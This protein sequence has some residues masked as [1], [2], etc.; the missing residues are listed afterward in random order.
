MIEVKVWSS[1]FLIVLIANCSLIASSYAAVPPLGDANCKEGS[2][3][4][5]NCASVD[6]SFGKMMNDPSSPCGCCKLCIFYIGENE[7][8]GVNMNNR[9]CG[10]GLTCAVQNP[11]SEYI[12]VKLETDCFKAQTDYDDRKSSGSLGMYETRPRCDDNGDFIARKCQP[13][14]SCYCVDVANNR[15]FGES[16]PSYATSD[17][18]MNCEC[19]RAYQ[20]AAQQDSLRT[21]QFP[22]CLPNGNYDLLQCV[23]Q[24]CFCIDSA[25]QTLTSSIQPITAI[26]E[27]PCYKADLH[28]P[29]YYRPCELE[30]IKAKMLTNSYNRQNITLI[31]IEQPDCSPDG[32]YQ[33]LILTKSTVY[34]ADPYGEKIEHFEIEKESANANSMNCKCARTRYW[35]TDQ[36]VAKPFCCTNGNYR[37][38][39]CRGGVCFCVDPDGNQ[40]GIE[41]QT[42]KLTELKCYQQ[43]QYPNC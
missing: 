7:A 34:C 5:A 36:N 17:V 26:M 35:L 25:N 14:S 20:V 16:P 31:G 10:P 8:C 30:R 3:D 1:T 18:A 39:Q 32:F 37:P 12:C 6:C 40:I 43:N 2:C 38:I 21:V 24:A 29:N 41:V 23:N 19:S 33:P 4:S 27:L 9:E 13:G 22:H 28:T 11:G 42:D 15:I